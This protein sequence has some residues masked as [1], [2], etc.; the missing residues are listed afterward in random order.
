ML[1]F[2]M[3]ALHRAG[4]NTDKN[5][6]LSGKITKKKKKKHFDGLHKKGYE[7]SMLTKARKRCHFIEKNVAKIFF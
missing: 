4:L 7:D 6:W 3:G 1:G 5:K 2:A